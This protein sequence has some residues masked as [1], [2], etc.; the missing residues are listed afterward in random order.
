[1]TL[2]VI[3]VQVEPLL[4]TSQLRLQL[5]KIRGRPVCHR[6]IQRWCRRG[7]PYHPHPANGKRQYVLREV[8]EW[9]RGA[10]ISR[11]LRQEATDRSLMPTRPR[12]AHSN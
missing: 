6:T 12:R 4:S 7:L 11:N 10:Q 9:L 8:Y 1:M 3:H 2:E 5:E